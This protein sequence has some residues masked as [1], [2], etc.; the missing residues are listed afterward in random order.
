MRFLLVL[1][2]FLTAYAPSAQARWLEMFRRTPHTKLYHHALPMVQRRAIV[3]S[4]NLKVN[5][6]MMLNRLNLPAVR[7][8]ALK[9]A[10]VSY[11]KTVAYRF[12]EVTVKPMDGAKN[13][14]E[15]LLLSLPASL[16]PENVFI[17]RIPNI[18]KP[19]EAYLSA[20]F[21]D[22]WDNWLKSGIGLQP[23]V[24]MAVSKADI[25][26]A[27]A[28]QEDLAANF[29]R[30]YEAM[31]QEQKDLRAQLSRVMIHVQEQTGWDDEMLA[32]MEEYFTG[33]MRPM[34]SNQDKLTALEFLQAYDVLAVVAEIGERYQRRVAQGVAPLPE[35]VISE[36]IQRVRRNLTE[37]FVPAEGSARSLRL[38][39]WY[40]GLFG[41][42]RF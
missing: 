7:L 37:G 22:T 29:A 3:S 40:N 38:Q 25:K 5:H 28:L 27:Q 32:V 36:S 42:E 21:A 13:T 20:L 23:P 39:K 41:Q 19:T 9:A 16:K 1:C 18:E 35:F 30:Q 31:P 34:I 2:L 24:E 12:P 17:E 8:P 26:T 10:S 11:Y 14:M 4:Y 15:D 33:V 6:V